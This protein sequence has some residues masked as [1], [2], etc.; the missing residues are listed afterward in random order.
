MTNAIELVMTDYPKASSF[1]MEAIG[2]PIE[3]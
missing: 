1:T 2:L 3:M